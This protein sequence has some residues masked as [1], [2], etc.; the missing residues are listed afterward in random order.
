MI[1]APDPPV[2]VIAHDLA[3]ARRR[4]SADRDTRRPSSFVSIPAVERSPHRS[5]S[6]L[7]G[8][9]AV[10]DPGTYGYEHRSLRPTWEHAWELPH[11]WRPDSLHVDSTLVYNIALPRFVS[12]NGKPWFVQVFRNKTDSLLCSLPCREL[13]QSTTWSRLAASSS[14]LLRSDA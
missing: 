8:T 9:N 12:S 6:L 1:L 5:A 2:A 7:V 3:P 14:V 13:R 4:D 11:E 10:N